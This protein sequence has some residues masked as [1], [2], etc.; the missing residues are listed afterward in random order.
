MYNPLLWRG[1][2]IGR[3]AYIGKLRCAQNSLT[4]TQSG[5]T[6]KMFLGIYY[7]QISA[8][9]VSFNLT[10]EVKTRCMNGSK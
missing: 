2:A 7:R 4:L 3:I 1:S 8:I 10:A 6:L 5:V 9:V